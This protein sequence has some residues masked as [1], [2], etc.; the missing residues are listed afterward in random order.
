MDRFDRI[1]ALHRIFVGRRT[2][3]ALDQLAERLEGS[4]PSVKRAIRTLRT[5]LGAPL[6]YDRARGGY[7]YRRSERTGPFE[8]PGLWFTPD[9][10]RALLTLQHVLGRLRP[11]LLTD[12]IAPLT[13]RLEALMSHRRLGLGEVHRRVR[14]LTQGARPAGPCFNAVA[15]GLLTRRRLRVTY[16][17]RGRGASTE[18]DLSP[19]RL[20][21]YRDS[22]YLDAYCH[23]RSA[24]RC[25]A[26]ERIDGAIVMPDA[27]R[28]VDDGELDAWFAEA[29][30]IFS[31]PA[32]ETAV[33]RFAPHRARWVADE[34]WHPR[35]S[36]RWLDDGRLEL[37]IPFGRPEELILDVMRFGPDVEVIA[38]PALRESV[39]E[40]LAAALESYDKKSTGSPDDPGAS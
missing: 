35:Q 39:R 12:E 24:L 29:Y 27:A 31:G 38:P 2:G 30:G 1:L 13:A 21:L 23:L 33:L 3:I 4:R 8:L 5:T 22:W 28:E 34:N 18:R 26:L 25:F 16:R 37:S 20:I 19:Q 9:E 11:G 7:F 6:E 14:V 32:T 15:S 36:T 40:R 17:G 10:I